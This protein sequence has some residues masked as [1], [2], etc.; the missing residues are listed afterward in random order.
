MTDGFDDALA[1][2][3]RLVALPLPG[4]RERV[5]DRT[6]LLL[7]RVGDPH[8][9][10]ATLHV[11]GSSG[12][13]S[14][15]TLAAAILRA[16]GLRVGLFTS[17]HLESITERIVVDGRPI[18]R[19]DWASLFALLRPTV[20]ALVA[21]SSAGQDLGRPTRMQVLWP[22]AA[23]YFA[24]LD[25]DIAVVEVG[26]GGKY[27]PTAINTARVG[28][29]TNV[30]LEHSGV[31]GATLAEIAHHKGAIAPRGGVLV[32]AAGQ[33]EV[34]DAIAAECR[35][36]DAALWRV[37]PAE[38]LSRV[39]TSEALPHAATTLEAATITHGGRQ[40]DRVVFYEDEGGLLRVAAPGLLY[41]DLTVGLRGR[42]QHVNATCAIAAV[43]ALT[44][45][46]VV[47]VG[48]DAV[49]VGLV[50]ARLAGRLEH[51]DDDPPTW[52]D[53][54]HNPDA[55]RTLAT[56]LHDLFPRRAL[57]LLLG[58]LEDKDS[59]AM[60]DALAPLAR[61]VVVTEPPWEGR[62][63]RGVHVARRVASHIDDCVY[64]RD[65]LEALTQARATARARGALL[66][67]TGSL[68]LVGFARSL[69]KGVDGA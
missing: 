38:A 63:G 62:N 18:P 2:L 58:V 11:T 57:V 53:G 3:D 41:D 44:L 61:A 55:A 47:E 30:S 17:P 33:P 64:I 5:L 29:V 14:T 66:V 22:L 9:R 24:A 36:R 68:I 32:T 59:D 34:L 42:H 25:V 12:K 7:D 39:A 65:P 20:D 46:G 40:N 16:A 27:D 67:V 8:E 26:M 51:V 50:S 43:D 45:L 21:G 37:V 15:A 6:R 28:V 31:L 49:R 48:L 1:Y 19:A 60:V 4:R 13:G 23:L 35:E 54:A 69:L 56:A 10:F 52:L